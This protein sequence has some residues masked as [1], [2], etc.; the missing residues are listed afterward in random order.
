MTRIAVAVVEHADRFL[1]GTRPEGMPL[2]G[3]AEFPG[4]KVREGETPS[5]AAVRECLEETGMSVTVG[6]L[7]DRTV[8]AYQHG[9]LELHFFAAEPHDPSQVPRPP[10]RWVARQELLALRF[11]PANKT[12][13]QRLIR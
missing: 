3:Y 4:G 13:L 7:Y 10:F 5:Q 11:P 12:V 6:Q 2:A 9:T 8:Q 1:V